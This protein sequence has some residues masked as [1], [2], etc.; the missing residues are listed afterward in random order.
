[1][2]RYENRS[3][4]AEQVRRKQDD[5]ERALMGDPTDRQFALQANFATPGSSFLPE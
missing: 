2:A 1:M 5:Q 3:A 4:L